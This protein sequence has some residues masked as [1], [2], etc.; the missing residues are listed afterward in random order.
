[1]KGIVVDD[2][3]GDEYEYLF[4]RERGRVRVREREGSREEERGYDEDVVEEEGKGNATTAGTG[5]RKGVPGNSS[6]DT[7]RDSERGREEGIVDGRDDVAGD[8]GEVAGRSDKNNGGDFR[9]KDQSTL[10]WRNNL[11]IILT[12]QRSTT[13][14]IPRFLIQGCQRNQTR[15]IEP[16]LCRTTRVDRAY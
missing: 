14:T 7:K 6:A 9:G 16:R 5:G 13:E 10:L 3:D 4:P 8:D 2:A 11:I 1:M 12:V 15:H